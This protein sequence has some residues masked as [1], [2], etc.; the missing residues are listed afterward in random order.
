MTPPPYYYRPLAPRSCRRALWH[1]YT[2]RCIY[3]ITLTRCV[4]VPR[5]SEIVGTLGS[6]YDKPRTALTALGQLV[7]AQFGKLEKAYA[8]VQILRKVVMPEHIHFVI[9][10]K[11]KTQHNLGEFINHFKNLCN[12]AYGGVQ[13]FEPLYHDRILMKKNQLQR[14][15]NYVSDNPRRRLERMAH[16]DLHCRSLLCDA[17]GVCYEAY[18]NLHLLDDPDIEAVKI[19]RAYGSEQLAAKKRLWMRTVQNGGVL[20]SPFISRAEQA[21]R[22]WTLENDGRIILLVDNGFGK[23]YSPKEPLHTIC[24]QGRLLIIAPTEH[25]FGACHLSRADCMHLNDLAQTVAV[26][27]LHT[28]QKP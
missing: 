2:D 21:V 8:F 6:Y 5:L 14:L 26:Y 24:S 28:C 11:E 20:V 7:T 18:G 1:D 4:N 10:I 9:Y 12:Q 22:K 19:S 25:Q 23:N 27:R 13:V 16:P 17:N 3:M 15:L